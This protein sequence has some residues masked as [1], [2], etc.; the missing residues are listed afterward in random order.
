MKISYYWYWTKDE[1]L[2][3]E[4]K[5][6]RRIQ[7]NANEKSVHETKQSKTSIKPIKLT[8]AFF[9]AGEYTTNN[10]NGINCTR[11]FLSSRDSCGCVSVWCIL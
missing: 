2:Y 11:F 1:K 8:T 9:V 7:Q 6:K 5:T 10:N 4:G 3:Y